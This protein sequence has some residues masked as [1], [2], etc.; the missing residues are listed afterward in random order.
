MVNL[1]IE[2]DENSGGDEELGLGFET[3]DGK[4]D[5]KKGENKEPEKNK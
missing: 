1:K 4:V 3:E 2:V 5:N